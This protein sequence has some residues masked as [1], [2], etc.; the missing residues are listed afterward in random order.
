MPVGLDCVYGNA[1]VTATNVTN[2]S[3]GLNTDTGIE[4][5]I[6]IG[7]GTIEMNGKGLPGYVHANDEVKAGTP[8]ISFDAAAIEEAGYENVVVV[9]AVNEISTIA[10][11]SLV[12]PE[13]WWS[14]TTRLAIL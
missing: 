12:S 14:S 7:V 11:T 2:H 5:L 6:H 13:H 4:I 1:R 3:I 10:L 8:S 9:T